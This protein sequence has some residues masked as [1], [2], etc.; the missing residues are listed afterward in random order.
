METVEHTIE[1]EGRPITY[2][3]TGDG[4][5]IVFVHGVWATGGVF[6]PVIDRL[7]E[8]FRCI[9]VH[10]PLGVHRYPSPPAVDHSPQALANIIAGLLAVLDIQDVTLVGN[11]TGGALCQ[12]VIAQHPERI[13]RLV[14]TN[15]DAFE[16]FPPGILKPLY[17]LA[18]VPLLWSAFAQLGRLALF[19]RL[20]FATVAHTPPDPAVLEMLMKRFA[21]V[22]GVREDLRQTI[23]GIYPSVTLEAAKTFA[24][25]QRDV[26]IVWGTDDRFF[27]VSLGRRLAAAFPRAQL[28]LIENARLFVSIDAP[29]AVS[30]AIADFV[31]AAPQQYANSLA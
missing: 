26:L 6:Y 24:S 5:P 11:D 17:A 9:N 31:N 15:C 13:G 28:K 20:L 29:D 23:L 1:L 14:L 19:R 7:A 27:P 10:L 18:R 3:V 16:M 22:P 21:S 12:L 30:A 25:F 4:P 8:R 2:D